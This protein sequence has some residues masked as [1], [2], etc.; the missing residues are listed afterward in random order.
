MSTPSTGPLLPEASAELF[1][2]V[3]Y[4]SELAQLEQTYASALSADVSAFARWLRAHAHLALLSFGAGGSLAVAELAA[5]LHQIAT[6]RLGRGG[7]PMDLYLLDDHPADT[8]LLL[9][10]ASGGHSD[11]LFAA[12]RL[13]QVPA[14]SAVFCGAEG[15][16]GEE[17]LA[18]TSVPVFAFDLLPDVHGWVAVNVLLAQA[19]VVARAYGEAFPQRV[20]SLPDRLSALLPDGLG[21]EA[22]VDLLVDRLGAVLARPALAFLHGPRTRGAQ[23]DFDSKFAESGLGELQ[24]SEF[25]N[26]AHGRYQALLPRMDEFGVL[27]FAT[28]EEL[29][30]ARATF[31][32]I[33]DAI[34][35]ELIEI[36]GEGPAAQQVASLATVLLA[37]GALGRVRDVVVGWGSRNTFGDVLYESELSSLIPLPG[38]R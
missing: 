2:V 33:P 19:V 14:P 36:G 27:G 29:P 31:D 13:P 26:F 3:T 28:A 11:S 8:A 17:L 10:T 20:G 37:I 7:E 22:S 6:G 25:R 12:A 24:S 9:V 1:T 38:G 15:S 23:R 21:V 5:T 32:A 16:K 4:A 18:G 35:H 34:P 30:I